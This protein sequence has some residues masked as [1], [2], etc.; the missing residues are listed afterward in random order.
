MVKKSILG[1]NNM[2]QQGN[3]LHI[4]VQTEY[5]NVEM[6]VLENGTPYLTERGLA[7]MCDIDPRGLHRLAAE[8]EEEKK[9]PRGE[10]IQEILYESGYTSNKLYFVAEYNGQKINAYTEQVCIALLEY[11]S[12]HAGDKKEHAIKAYRRLATQTFRDFIYTGTK[13]SPEQ[14]QIESWNNFHDRVNILSNAVP[15]G[16]FGVFNEIAGMIVPMIQNGAYVSCHLVPDI[17]VGIMWGKHW[18]KN[19]LE[20]IHGKRIQYEHRYPD[21][22]PQA[23]SNPQDAY[24]YPVAALGEFRAWLTNDYIKNYYQKYVISKVK[25]N[26]I[27]SKDGRLALNAFSE[28]KSLPS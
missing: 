7:R 20:E 4:A 24:A 3:L 10:K 5:D 21:Y 26:S 14:R 25:D 6:G 12:F 11:Y 1:N 16:Y 8:W 15:Q 19:K 27:S 2:P 18:K 17:S 22:Y 28:N 9:R 23:R 13:Y